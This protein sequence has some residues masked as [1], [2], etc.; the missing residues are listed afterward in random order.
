MSA[1]PPEKA[2]AEQ[3]PQSGDEAEHMERGEAGDTSGQGLGDFEVKEQDRWLPIANGW[4][5]PS[6]RRPFDRRTGRAP[7]CFDLLVP[8]VTLLLRAALD[9]GIVRT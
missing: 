8:C 3:G 1:S 9:Y 2:E 5:F 4:S 7:S 6:S